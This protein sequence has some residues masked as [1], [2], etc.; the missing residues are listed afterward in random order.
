L[1]ILIERFLLYIVFIGAKKLY[2][3]FT[4]SLRAIEWKIKM[5]AYRQRKSQQDVKICFLGDNMEV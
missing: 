2:Q 5:E 1:F 3:V 4:M